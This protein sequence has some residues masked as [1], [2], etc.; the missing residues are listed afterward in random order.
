M[1][2][3]VDIL[4]FPLQYRGHKWSRPHVISWLLCALAG[5]LYAA[6]ILLDDTRLVFLLRVLPWL[7][8]AVCCAV[9]DVLV[10][11]HG[12]LPL[13]LKLNVQIFEK[14]SVKRNKEEEKEENAQFISKWRLY[15]S[16]TPFSC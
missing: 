6:A 10:S 12:V 5:A 11:L 1:F 13:A 14:L 2:C 7:M 9:L 8:S 16:S 3:P 4:L 15:P